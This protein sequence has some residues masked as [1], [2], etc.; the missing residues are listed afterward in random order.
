M[1]NF[2]AYEVE[3]LAD[4]SYA[5]KRVEKELEDLP[6]GEV[7]IDV[8]YSSVNYKDALSASGNKGVTRNFPHTPGI[9][10]VGTVVSS[11]SSSVAVGSG[12][13]VTGYDLGMGTAGGFGQRIRVPAGWVAQLPATLAP[14]E[15]MCLGTAGLTAALCID[16]LL[17]NGL[18]PD[19]G[20]VLVTGATGGVGILACALLSKL[21]FEVVASTGKPEAA[22]RLKE[23]GVAELLPRQELS[24]E[25]SRPLLK[26]SYAAAVDV[27]GGN[28]LANV[29]KCIKAG[30]SVAACGLVESPA[31]NTTVLPFILRGVNLL[32]VDS[33]EIPLAKKQAMW[34]LLA[35]DWY[36]PELDSLVEEIGY[37]ELGSALEKVL[38]GG[39][40]GRYVLNLA[41]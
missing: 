24:A 36:L 30:G 14:K 13:L 23:L 19:D 20:K 41:Q 31:L 10:A 8:S 18:T 27:V 9:D 22:Q 7:V 35:S 28:T 25:N 11:E 12:V 21:G 29:L 15:S 33:V 3:E 2:S 6:A 40:V 37:A 34:D 32:G 39:A 5:G 38:A 26:E 16:K 17:N 1:T 4:G